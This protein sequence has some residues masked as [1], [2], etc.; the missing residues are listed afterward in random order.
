MCVV[1]VNHGVGI[2]KACNRAEELLWYGGGPVAGTIAWWVVA[3]C[4]QDAVLTQ[5]CKGLC[6]HPTPCRH[7][8]LVRVCV[9]Y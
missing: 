5:S 2:I 7:D 3:A 1:L 9:F 4:M 6:M 8:D